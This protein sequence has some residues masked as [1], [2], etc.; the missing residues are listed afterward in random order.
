TDSVMLNLDLTRFERKSVARLR[1]E[2][3]AIRAYLRRSPSLYP[4][5]PFTRAPLVVYTVPA[6]ATSPALYY[7]RRYEAPISI[8]T[9]PDVLL[10][11]TLV[12]SAKR[13]RRVREELLTLSRPY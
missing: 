9:S 10:N 3:L 6:L 8:Y 11:S 12:V 2:E 13:I 1:E 7:Y 5:T 4:V